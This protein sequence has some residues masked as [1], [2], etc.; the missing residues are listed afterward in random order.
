ME[1]GEGL[2]LGGDALISAGTRFFEA[3]HLVFEAPE[4]LADRL[5]DVLELFAAAIQE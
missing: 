4:G 1:I 5:D 2:Q 3:L